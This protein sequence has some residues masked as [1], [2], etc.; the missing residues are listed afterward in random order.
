[1]TKNQTLKIFEDCI[2]SKTKYNSIKEL[3]KFSIRCFK[4]NYTQF[5]KNTNYFTD[6][7]FGILLVKKSVYTHLCLGPFNDNF[8]FVSRLNL[9]P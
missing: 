2:I 5:E 7:E 1:M 3:E 4:K 8:Y 6:S 9:A